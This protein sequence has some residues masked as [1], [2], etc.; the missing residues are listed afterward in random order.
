MALLKGK[1]FA[2]VLFAGALLGS[3]PEVQIPPVVEQPVVRIISGGGS[4]QHY[5]REKVKL[6]KIDKLKDE[7][8]RMAQ[9]HADD[10][11]ILQLI[12]NA[13]LSNILD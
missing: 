1:L 9:L 2:G 11:I 8:M 3:A 7:S 5:N 10:E 13:T 4:F 12:I 6:P